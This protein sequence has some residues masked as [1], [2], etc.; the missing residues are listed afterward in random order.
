MTDESSNYTSQELMY[1]VRVSGRLGSGWSAWF[2]DLGIAVAVDG[3]TLL[4]GPVVDQAALHGVLRKVRDLG[5][6]LLSV[7]SV[8]HPPS[9]PTAD[10]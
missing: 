4:V 10:E 7:E 3:G 2:Q 8:P 5:L 1:E 6:T 9:S